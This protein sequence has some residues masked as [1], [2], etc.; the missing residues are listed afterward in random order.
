[1]E[2]GLLFISGFAVVPATVVV[3]KALAHYCPGRFEG[4]S[5]CS[6]LIYRRDQAEEWAEVAGL[7]EI[8]MTQQSH[9][10]GAQQ[11]QLAKQQ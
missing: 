3:M 7:E 2:F 11:Q 10:Q 8:A 1:M 9:P 5:P 4:F 6:G